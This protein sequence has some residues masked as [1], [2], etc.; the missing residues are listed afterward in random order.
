[1]LVKSKYFSRPLNAVGSFGWDGEHLIY[2]DLMEA[3]AEKI[4][5]WVK[6]DHQA[7]IVVTGGT[8]TGKSNWGIKFCRTLNRDWDIHSNLLYSLE[9]LKVKLNSKNP[10]PVNLFDEGSLIFNSLDTTSRDGKNLA[11]L[12]DMLRSRHMITVIVMPSDKELNKRIGKHVDYWVECPPNA[13]IP[14]YQNRGFYHI[15]ERTVYK[16]GKVWETLIGTGVYSP[17]SSKMNNIYQTIKR[18]KQDEYMRRIGVL[19]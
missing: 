15:R 12:F 3:F 13:P 5:D 2:S 17:I 11:V 14:G 4:K 8:G 7:V 9:D 19:E 6:S 1:M 18:Q 16:S 10:D